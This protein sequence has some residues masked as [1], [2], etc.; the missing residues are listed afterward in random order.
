MKVPTLGVDSTPFELRF[1]YANENR[2]AT[3][4]LGGTGVAI[5]TFLLIFLSTRF[6]AGSWGS[7]LFQFTL[8]TVVLSIFFL[9]ISGSH[10]YFLIE[11]L[12]RGLPNTAALLRRADAF[13]VL[14][15]ALLLLE[16]A[17]IL[18]TLEIYYIGAAALALWATSLLIIGRGR[19]TLGTA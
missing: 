2:Q 1:E 8:L 10:Y 4:N 5:L 9:G 3:I 15:L 6:S 17:L 18:I 13:F 14:G 7:L 16:P 11:A 12:E 19:T